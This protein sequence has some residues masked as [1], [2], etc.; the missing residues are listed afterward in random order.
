MAECYRIVRP[1]GYLLTFSDWRQL[2]T[3]SDAIQVA[4]WT[5]RGVVVWDKT[6]G[7]RPQMGWFRAQAEYVL[8]ASHGSL[9]REQSR[10]VRVC[11]PGVIR[12]HHS[13]GGKRHAAAKPIPVM[14]HLMSIL[15]PGSLIL[16]PFAGSGSTAIAAHQSG[17]RSLSVEMAPEY[18]NVIV[19]RLTAALT[20]A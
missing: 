5:W 20:P 10:A 7:S 9:G 13:T 3:F 8:T 14:A 17:H 19:D 18:C 2:P 16:D 1:G 4:G 11:A 12:A 15:P 6:E